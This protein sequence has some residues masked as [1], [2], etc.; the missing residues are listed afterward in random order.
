L[1]ERSSQSKILRQK[2]HHPPERRNALG[3]DFYESKN[4]LKNAKKHPNV[5]FF[6][7]LQKKILIFAFMRD[8]IPYVEKENSAEMNKK[9]IYPQK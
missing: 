7:L 2:F 5:P 4:S 9:R 3:R 6:S 1:T 8:I